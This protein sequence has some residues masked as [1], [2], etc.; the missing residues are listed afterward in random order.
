MALHQIIQFSGPFPNPDSIG[1]CRLLTPFRSIELMRRRTTC[2]SDVVS[3]A[4]HR[5]CAG[6]Y[7]AVGDDS[8]GKSVAWQRQG[9]ERKLKELV[10]LAHA[11]PF[12]SEARQMIAKRL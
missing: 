12:P 4:R 9:S 3:H 8:F 5:D 10:F 7:V 2:Q 6:P 11:P 1:R